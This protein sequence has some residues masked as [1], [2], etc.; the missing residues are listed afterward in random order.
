MSSS[1]LDHDNLKQVLQSSKV[2]K[3]NQIKARTRANNGLHNPSCYV[4]GYNWVFVCL[5]DWF[6]FLFCFFLF[7][8]FCFVVFS[9]FAYLFLFF[10][11]YYY[12]ES[13][14]RFLR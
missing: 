5:V 9:L 10:I 11:V 14:L 7:C 4:K 2:N 3:T 8:L 12:L 1:A 13:K 6:C